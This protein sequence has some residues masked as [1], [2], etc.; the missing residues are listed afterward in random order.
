VHNGASDLEARVFSPSVS[1]SKPYGSSH[2]F[3]G[4]IDKSLG[5]GAQI[6]NDHDEK[7][8][9]RYGVTDKNRRV[10]GSATSPAFTGLGFNLGW[11]DT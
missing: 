6:M 1:F 3:L 2:R 10:L 11:K 7:N 9:G 8:S 5:K 4:K